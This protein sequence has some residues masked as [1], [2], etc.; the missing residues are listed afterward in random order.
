MKTV[1]ILS[2]A[3]IFSIVF[4]SCKNIEEPKVDVMSDLAL[5]SSTSKTISDTFLYVTASTGLSLREY[6][7]LQS[8]K[9]AIMPYGTKVKVVSKERNPT[10]TVGGI[11]GGMDQIEFNHKKGFAFNGFLSKFFPPEKD[12]SAKGYAE[13]LKGNFSAISFSESTSG[14]ASKPV[15]TEILSLPDSKWHEAFYI[16][17]KLYDFPSEFSFPNPKGKNLQTIKDS[18][19]KKNVW[20]SELQITRKDNSF[21]KIEYVYKTK[22]GFSKTVSIFK[23]NNVMKLVKTER[24]E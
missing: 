24:V 17:Q 16:A 6:N 2:I 4:I 14:T 22:K 7:N 8:N 12:I 13:E 21:S 5:A 9:L 23:E 10:M 11:Q 20:V 1:K 19:P 18:K 3:F 15:N